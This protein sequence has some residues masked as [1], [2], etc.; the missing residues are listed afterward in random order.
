MIYVNYDKNVTA[1]NWFLILRIDFLMK[2]T[3]INKDICLMKKNL[4]TKVENDLELK[5]SNLAYLMV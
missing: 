5:K 3:V 2:N 4:E 1:R